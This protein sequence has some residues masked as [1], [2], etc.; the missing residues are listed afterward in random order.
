MT[1]QPPQPDPQQPGSGQP[2][3]GQ[4]QYGQPQYGQPQYGQ[5]QY[6]Q[7][8]FYSPPD[9]RSATTALVLGI[10]GLVVCPLVLS[11]PALVI[12]RKAVQEIDA[13]NGQLG[14]RGNAQAGYIL[15][16]VGTAWAAVIALFFLVVVVIGGVIGSSVDDSCSTVSDGSAMTTTC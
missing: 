14:G 4:P 12:G 1:E 9:H 5:P 2:Q 8:P 7:P 11:I 10:L 6:G 16:I 15:G 13:S 3:Y